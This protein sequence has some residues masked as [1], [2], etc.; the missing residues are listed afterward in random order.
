MAK[1]DLVPVNG[2]VTYGSLA[3]DFNAFELEGDQAVED[4][5]AYG[6][7]KCAQNIGSGTP[8][9]QARVGG[10]GKKGAANTALGFDGTGFSA[11]GVS[12]SVTL[13]TGV[14]EA[15]TFVLR[16]LRVVHARMRAVIPVTFELLNYNDP[17]E[18]WAVS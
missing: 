13:D 14:T 6:T 8:S 18:T 4:K 5:T 11:T 12:V 17:T 15:G 3:I 7:N 10:F 16:R 1:T 9:I 2:A